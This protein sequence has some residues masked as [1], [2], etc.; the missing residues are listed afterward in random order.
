MLPLV[1]ALVLAL[2]IV[3][4]ALRRRRNRLLPPG[5]PGKLLVGNLLD[6]PRKDEWLLYTEYARVYAG[7][8]VCL[9][10]LGQTLIILSA[11]DDIKELLAARGAIYSGRMRGTMVQQ[12]LIG[13]NRVGE[14]VLV[15]PLGR[16]FRAI[17]RI[18]AAFLGP[19]AAR[20]YADVQTQAVTECLRRL[21][22]KQQDPHIPLKRMIGGIVLRLAYGYEVS[23]DDDHFVQLAEKSVV[24]FL[25]ALQPGWVVDTFPALMNLPSWLPFA[26]FKRKAE[27][28]HQDAERGLNVPWQWVKNRLASGVATPSFAADIIE[29]KEET[30]ARTAMR[31]IYGAGMDTTLAASLWL[32]LALALHPEVQLRAQREIDVVTLGERLPTLDDRGRLPYIDAIIKEVLRWHPTV[33]LATAVPHISTED[34]T[35]RGYFIPKGSIVVPNVWSILHDP[36]KYPEPAM[37]RPERHLSHEGKCNPDP[38]NYVFGFGPRQCPGRNLADT[39]LYL[40]ASAIL[41][42]CNVSDAINGRNEI[43]MPENVEYSSGIISRPTPFS[44]RITPRTEQ[45]RALLY[46]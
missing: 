6:V 2:G 44:C 10:V 23:S 40:L 42:T 13:G 12:Q 36:A 33:N 22:D 8:I 3:W 37:F 32:I 1:P 9:R 45:T 25:S 30:A 46:E 18:F 27:K 17:R 5:P 16:P 11:E 15:L 24:A 29:D 39:T 20:R 31:D 43:L 4:I 19:Q 34:D 14:G 26:G 38:Y 21:V 28:W 35:Y 41:A 7:D